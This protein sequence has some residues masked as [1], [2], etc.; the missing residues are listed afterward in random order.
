MVPDTLETRVRQLLDDARER[1]H[2]Y[3]SAHYRK[4]GQPGEDGLN[5]R[6]EALEHAAIEL[7]QAVDAASK[8]PKA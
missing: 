5:I 8:K 3:S 4:P 6:L 7:A 1:G 2:Q